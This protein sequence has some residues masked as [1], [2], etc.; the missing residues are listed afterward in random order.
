M[1]GKKLLHLPLLLSVVVIGV[2]IGIGFIKA[3]TNPPA[4]VVH[5]SNL[6]INLTPGAPTKGTIFLKNTT[7]KP[8]TIQT[9]I[10]NFTAQGEEGGV[11]LT[12]DNTP[13]SMS[14]WV[15]ITPE[16]IDIQAQQE[17]AFS[18]T[19]TPPLSAEPG[20]HFGSIVF[21]TI[22]ST[23]NAGAG[24]AISQEIAALILAKIP[25]NVKEDALV[26]S[27]TTEKPF[28]EF[29]PVKFVMRVKN[30]GDIHVQPFG[31]IQVKDMLGNKVDTTIPPTNILPNAVRKIFISYPH[32]LLIGKYTATIVASYG[33]KNQPLVGSVE[34]YAFPIRYGIVLLV[35][36]IV[37]LL[38]RKRIFKAFK[39]MATGK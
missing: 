16:K 17:V 5:P 9:S 25:G 11:D 10:K 35:I 23:V 8:V 13:F 6:E 19:I 1:K 7:D 15:R 4:L 33:T 27:L 31:A 20:G 18:Y 36:L 14:S 22:P 3:Q 38:L 2:I 34:F 28:Y 26:E 29:G 39:M 12:S 21:A 24:S 30:Q 37:L 32:H